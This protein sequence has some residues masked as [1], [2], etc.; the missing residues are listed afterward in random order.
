M[1]LTLLCTAATRLPSTI[2]ATAIITMIS[3]ID[4]RFTCQRPPFMKTRISAAKPAALEPTE[5]KAVAG[6]G[7]PW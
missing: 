5:K 7:A 4:C 2:V 1:R 3:T 6:V